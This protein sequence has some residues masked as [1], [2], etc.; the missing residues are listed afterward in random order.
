MVMK[1]IDMLRQ[2]KEKKLLDLYLTPYTKS[3]SKCITNLNVK[4][5][6]IKLIKK[7]REN[8]WDLKPG[9]EF[10]NSTL[11]TQFIKGKTD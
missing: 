1:Q 4:C 6:S 7:I 11:R 10:L 9:K 3:N 2:K 8:L 5:E